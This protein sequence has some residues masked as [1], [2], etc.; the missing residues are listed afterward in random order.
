MKSLIVPVD[1]SQQSEF[2]LQT[3]AGLARS[4]DAELIVV[5]MLELNYAMISSAEAFSAQQSVLL[6]K[7]AEKRL[8]GFLDKPYLEGIRVTP[9]IKHYKVFSEV[10][11]IAEKHDAGL[12]VMGSHGSD[13]LE[14]L[15]IGS[16]AERVVRHS[17]VPVLVVKQAPGD[18]SVDTVVFACDFSDEIL[19]AYARALDF[20][21]DLGASFLPV[22]VNTPGDGFLS[23]A[24]ANARIAEFQRQAGTGLEADIYNDYSV[25]RGV[26]AYAEA[27]NADLIA[28]PTH[29]RKGITHFF[30]GSIGEDIANHS[31]LPVLTF[32]I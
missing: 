19:P 1:F 22:Y 26:L 14:E 24:E 25:E 12:I 3:A 21:E 28:I 31:R 2:A 32:R 30:M 4:R 18:F 20:A 13:G 16:N 5:H 27:V 15:F 7:A 8:A 10:N 17:E 6:L 11:E 23:T 9:V 29:G